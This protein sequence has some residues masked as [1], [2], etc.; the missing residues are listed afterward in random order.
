MVHLIIFLA[1][2][3]KTRQFSFKGLVEKGNVL[4]FVEHQDFCEL[5][6]QSTEF[7]Q[8]HISPETRK[9]ILKVF[10]N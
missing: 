4:L 10:E 9:I 1:Q 6:V 7:K 5:S 2:V 8:A 3:K